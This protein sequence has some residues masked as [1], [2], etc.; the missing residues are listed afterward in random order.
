LT[1]PIYSLPVGKRSKLE[2]TALVVIAAFAITALGPSCSKAPPTGESL[3]KTC[4]TQS[5]EFVRQANDWLREFE[6][7]VQ[8]AQMAPPK[9]EA[10]L[11]QIGN[12][13]QMRRRMQD[14]R[15]PAC[16]NAVKSL[17]LLSIDT[18]TRSLATWMSDRAFSGIN[19]L[20]D[21]QAAADQLL[22]SRNA[23]AYLAQSQNKVTPLTSDGLRQIFAEL[24]WKTESYQDDKNITVLTATGAPKLLIEA[25]VSDGVVFTFRIRSLDASESNL[26]K[27]LTQALI[28]LDRVMPDSPDRSE[29][30]TNLKPK[31][32][33]MAFEAASY[34]RGMQ[35]VRVTTGYAP[36]G[37]GKV[38]NELVLELFV[39][40]Q[41]S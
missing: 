12:L 6:D 10:V 24:S 26:Q 16:A 11:P 31:L 4:G 8:V 32:S 27:M 1:L 33:S 21:S 18:Y 41:I 29:W 28:F 35:T 9:A 38:D 14:L 5:Q 13:K 17:V 7:V 34:R 23:L 36:A 25:L 2:S 19:S 39:P 15:P 20:E 40:E 30:V 37:A 22:A 3:G